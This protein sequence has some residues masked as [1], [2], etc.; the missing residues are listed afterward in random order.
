MP[1]SKLRRL[2][3]KMRRALSLEEVR[4][5]SR[6][7]QENIILLEAYKAAGTIALYSS[8]H[9]EVLMN[10]IARDAAS[11]GKRLL[12]PAMHDGVLLFRE[13]IAGIKMHPGAFG[14]LEPSKSGSIIDPAQIDLI[15][16]P[17]VAFDITGHRVGYGK[18]CYDRALHNLEGKGRMVGACYD[19]QLV[20]EIV[21]EPHDVKL[22]IIVTDNRVVFAGNS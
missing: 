1:K 14:I 11:S 3:L 4:E 19:F 2:M 15:V 12:F 9:N 5:K 17:G 8:I 6:L 18:G 10:L 7:V 21:G 16:V 22:D 20:D 13:L